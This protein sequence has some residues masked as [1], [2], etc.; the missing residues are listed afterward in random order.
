MLSERQANPDNGAALGLTV[1]YDY[2]LQGSLRFTRRNAGR[3]E[4]VVEQRYDSHGRLVKL[5][6]PDRGVED[7]VYNA[8]GELVRAVDGSNQ[9]IL[10]HFD[11]LGRR[12][13]RVSGSV[14][15][16]APPLSGQI[17]GSGFES[18]APL[19]PQVIDVWQYD[20]ASK[21]LGA[22]E[23]ETRSSADEATWSRTYSF[24][25]YGRPISVST[26]LDGTS[27]SES[28]AYDG[29]GR[30]Y[31]QTDASGKTLEQTYTAKGHP[32]ALLDP[33]L[34]K[35]VYNRVREVNARGQVTLERRGDSDALAIR[36][37][38]DPQRGWL[39]DIQS[40]SGNSLQNLG[41]LYNAIGRL[42]W[43]EDRR[44]AQ[45]EDFTYDALN[46]L[47]TVQRQGPSWCEQVSHMTPVWLMDILSPRQA[48]PTAAHPPRPHPTATD[49][50]NG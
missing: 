3:G 14:Q 49:H 8:A 47:K 24:D 19:S 10:Q 29:F 16:S 5:L 12:W 28:T 20:T 48:D 18:S 7:Y 35:R 43:R 44:T 6:D 22:L 9:E 25:A 11:A 33:A 50:A 23:V 27:Y 17:F 38:F 31:R 39:T 15:S 46:R 13:K 42:E 45:R 41:Y 1:S 36:R 2:D 32:E 4:I 34:R 40:G 26:L 30:P 37:S 21:G